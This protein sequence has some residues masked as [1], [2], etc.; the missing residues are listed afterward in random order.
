MPE[1]NPINILLVDDDEVE[2]LAVKRAFARARVPSSITVARD[3]REAL[4]LLKE[5]AVPDPRILLLDLNMPRMTGI[6]FLA[7]IRRD[8]RL[9]DQVVFVLTTSKAE[10]DILRTYDLG[11]NS[12]ITKPVSFA[13]LVETVR[14]LGRYWLEIVELPPDGEE[15]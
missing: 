10:E 14:M 8:P 15:G 13:S 2:A 4:E 11:V 1:S 12:F 7:E 9:K 6:E 3:G 5:E